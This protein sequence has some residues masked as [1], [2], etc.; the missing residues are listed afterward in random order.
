LGA[1]EKIK[2][3]E[4]KSNTAES[5]TK[6]FFRIVPHKIRMQHRFANLDEMLSLVIEHIQL[7]EQARIAYLDCLEKDI[8]S[9][10]DDPAQHDACMTSG[11]VNTMNKH[12]VQKIRKEFFGGEDIDFPESESKVSP[13]QPEKQS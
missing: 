4:I 11:L 10:L 1:E 6:M 7:R 3:A 9:Y 8:C 13:Y 12:L 2:M 5:V